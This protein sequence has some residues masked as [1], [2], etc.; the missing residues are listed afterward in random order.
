[1]EVDVVDG[2]QVSRQLVQDPPRGSVPY[3]NKA[4]C[5]SCGHHCAVRAPLAVQKVLLEVVLQSIRESTSLSRTFQ[6]KLVRNPK[7][8]WLPH[9]HRENTKTNSEVHIDTRE[10]A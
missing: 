10:V 8:L 6:G 9:Y 1:M 7:L 4:V 5:R 3:V 2:T